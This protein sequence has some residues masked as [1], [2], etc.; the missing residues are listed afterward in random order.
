MGIGKT[1]TGIL[2]LGAVGTGGYLIGKGACQVK[3]YGIKRDDAGVYIEAK[4]AGKP[5][6]RP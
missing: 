1:L 5:I 2:L 4:K 6:R 3:E